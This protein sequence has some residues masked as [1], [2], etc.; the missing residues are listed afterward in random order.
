MLCVPYG[1]A[2][3]PHVGDRTPS[4]LPASHCGV[5]QV[6]PPTDPVD[7]AAA[8]AAA[9]AALAGAVAIAAIAAAMFITAAIAAAIAAAVA[10]ATTG[11][12]G[13]GIERRR[14]STSPLVLSTSPAA[15]DAVMSVRIM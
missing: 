9:L 10:F 12:L 8:P 11:V 4:D 7:A 5:P 2:C 15:R 1:G 3:L 6:A 13:A 14:R